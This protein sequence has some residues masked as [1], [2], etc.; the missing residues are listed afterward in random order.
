M[1]QEQTGA[2]VE[3]DSFRDVSFIEYKAAQAKGSKYIILSIKNAL[4]MS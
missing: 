4:V 3:H 2:K 1:V